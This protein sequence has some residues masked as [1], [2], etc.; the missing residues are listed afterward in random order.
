MSDPTKALIDECEHQRQVCEYTAVSFLIWLRC[1][2]VIRAFL[3]GTPVLTGGITVWK[4]AQQDAPS[5]SIICAF[6]TVTLPLLNRAFEFDQRIDAYT[7]MAGEFTNL[8]DCFRQ[9]A[10]IHSLKPYPEFEE[11]VKPLFDRMAK[12]SKQPLTPPEWSFQ[13]ARRKIKAGHYQRDED[14]SPGTGP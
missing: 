8:R 12:A 11:Q 5:L 3:L 6:L 10:T 4:S 9:A 14:T 7:R 2:R 1:L 13:R